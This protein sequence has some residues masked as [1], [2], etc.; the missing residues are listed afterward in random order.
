MRTLVALTV[1]MLA[2]AS[3]VWWKT[4]GGGQAPEELPAT[5]GDPGE[6]VATIGPRGGSGESGLSDASSRQGGEA[7][8]AN[9][10][11]G[12]AKPAPAPEG[13][14]ESGEQGE[15]PAPPAVDPEPTP[16]PT[17]QEVQHRVKPGETLYRIVLNAYGTAPEDLVDKVA[18]ENG[19]ADPGSI[20]EGQKLKLPVIAGYPE[21]SAG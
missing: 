3:A 10:R 12:G 6:G 8:E 5:T 19:L 14:E 20:S 1:L 11:N 2:L 16:P 9:L 21:P 15:K 17:P 18:D 4:T 7:G 13:G